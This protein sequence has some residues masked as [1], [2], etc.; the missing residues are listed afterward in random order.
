MSD[1]FDEVQ[2]KTERAAQELKDGTFA[3]DRVQLGESPSRQENLQPSIS[4]A[5][6]ANVAP[7]RQDDLPAPFLE[8]TL[9]V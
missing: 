8:I 7:G 5:P 6:T 4:L 2:A 3:Q 1:Q 9:S